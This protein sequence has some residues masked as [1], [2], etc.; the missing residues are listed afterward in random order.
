NAKNRL[1]RID[2]VCPV[3][4]PWRERR[5]SRSE[6]YRRNG[7]NGSD[8]VYLASAL[9]NSGKQLGVDRILG[10]KRHDSAHFPSELVGLRNPVSPS[11]ANLQPISSRDE[12]FT[13][14]AIIRPHLHRS[15]LKIQPS[16]RHGITPHFQPTLASKWK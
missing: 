15:G 4:L 7:T 12:V 13:Y 10:H 11:L 16:R 1:E 3:K 14:V 5:V 6:H 2:E 8:V 9:A